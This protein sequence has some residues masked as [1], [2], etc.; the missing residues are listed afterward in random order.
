MPHPP[1]RLLSVF[2]AVA[3]TGSMQG[4]AAELNVSQPAISQAVRSLEEHVGAPL[5]DRDR[6][7]V[8]PTPAGAILAAEI[9]A[10]LARIGDAVQT[11]RDEAGAR[12][13]AVTVACSVGV[14]THWLMP[15]LPAFYRAH[16]DL[17]VNVMTT[18]TGVPALGDGVDL[19]I[20]FGH[21]RWTDGT[22][23][24][25]F[26]EDVVPLCA[27]ALRARLDTG[28]PIEVAPLL[29]VRSDEASWLTWDDYWRR[30][31]L[32]RGSGPNQS[33]TNYVQ[34]TQA[35]L[36]GHGI[37]LGWRSITSALV[38]E[39]RLVDAGLPSI[40]APDAFYLAA[41]RKRG[42]KASE[43]FADWLTAS[44]APPN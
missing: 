4:A 44:S 26:D 28:L 39:G 18:Q 27:P 19:A 29:H 31:N 1:L 43:T 3:R 38:A 17:L 16:P 2:A 20:R 25:L 37:M 7:P 15:R 41:R 24:H 30:T 9:E 21:G 40:P 14:A 36:E 8:R 34:T 11:V 23:R 42:A 22:V 12:A 6:R 5:L 33:F 13:N 35:A 32:A 10:G